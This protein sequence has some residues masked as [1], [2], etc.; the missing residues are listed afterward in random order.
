M[1]RTE[2]D[3]DITKWRAQRQSL[4]LMVPRMPT[5]TLERSCYALD[6]LHVKDQGRQIF[7]YLP[8]AKC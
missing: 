5:G 1:Q 2:G 8:P 3:N 7:W 4:E 6:N